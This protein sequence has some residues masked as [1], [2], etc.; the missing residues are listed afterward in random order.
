MA[1]VDVAVADAYQTAYILVSTD[2][3][4]DAHIADAAFAAQSTYDAGILVRKIAV[5]VGVLNADV[6]QRVVLAVD[7]AHEVVGAVV[8][9]RHEVVGRITIHVVVH[10]KVLAAV[11]QTVTVGVLRQQFPVVVGVELVRIL[12]RAGAA[13]GHV[14]ALQFELAGEVA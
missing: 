7:V 14:R 1:V 10:G 12:L 3:A 11:A 13:E 5:L 9:H 2:A 4:V 6:F 8:S